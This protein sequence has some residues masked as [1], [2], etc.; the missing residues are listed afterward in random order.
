MTRAFL[1]TTSH[2][3]STSARHTASEDR[4]ALSRFTSTFSNASVLLR[5]FFSLFTPRSR[6][7]PAEVINTS[8]RC[9][10][11][12]GARQDSLSVFLAACSP[13]LSC[14]RRLLVPLNPLTRRR[15][16]WWEETG[17]MLIIR[18]H[19]GLLSVSS[20]FLHVPPPSRPIS[21]LLTQ[22]ITHSPL[23]LC[24]Q[25]FTPQNLSPLSP[26]YPNAPL[27][28]FHSSLRLLLLPCFTPLP[29]WLCPDH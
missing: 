1:K 29:F 19:F 10:L 2:Y 15:P 21:T 25:P 4:Q 24:L 16:V 8:S 13:G 18:S 3:P 5:A 27:S 7:G 12:G 26:S 28:L 22:S 23:L 9:G 14:S 6:P 11:L 20:S 17:S